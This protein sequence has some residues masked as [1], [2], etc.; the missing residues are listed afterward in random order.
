M[1]ACGACGCGLWA[2]TPITATLRACAI[3]L[4]QAFAPISPPPGV[5]PTNHVNA[6]R[7]TGVTSPRAL[8]RAAQSTTPTVLLLMLC[9]ALLPVLRVHVAYVHVHHSVN[10]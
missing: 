5:G 9:L 8:Q 4:A 6:T 3:T 7:P 1:G 10:A 2:R